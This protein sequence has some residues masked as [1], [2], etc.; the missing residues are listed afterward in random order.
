MLANAAR[1]AS[2]PDLTREIS[3]EAEQAAV[4]QHP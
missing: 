4:L 1:G 3:P 2:Q